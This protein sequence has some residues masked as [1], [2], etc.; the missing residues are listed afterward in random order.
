MDVMIFVIG[1]TMIEELIFEAFVSVET[2]TYWKLL[3][4]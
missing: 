2:Q 1:Q 4:L 3:D